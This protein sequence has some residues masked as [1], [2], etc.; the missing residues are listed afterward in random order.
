MSDVFLSLLQYQ[1]P[2]VL[3]NH[4]RYC[5]LQ[6]LQHVVV[7]LSAAPSGQ[8]RLI[9]QLEATLHH[10]LRL[11]AD[12]VLVCAGDQVCVYGQQHAVPS[13][14]AGHEQ[15]LS[16]MW[17]L[18]A[19]HGQSERVYDLQLWRHTPAVVQRLYDALAASK[20]ASPAPVAPGDLFGDGPW[21]APDEYVNGCL[22]ALECHQS[23]LVRWQDR[24]DVW[25]LVM[26]TR[27]G[28]WM[29]ASYRRVV[30]EAVNRM[31]AGGPRVFDVA[32][33]TVP[34]QESYTV[35]QPQGRVAL[36]MLYTPNIRFYGQFAECNV[37]RYCARH[38]YAFHVY[39][40]VPEGMP[41]GV[42]GNWLKPHLLQRHLPDHEWVVWVDADMMFL[43]QS[44]P[45]EPLLQGRDVLAAHDIGNWVLNS[46]L[47]GFRQ[48]PDNARVLAE[49]VNRSEQLSDRSSV[50][51]SDGDQRV[52][53]DVL[54]GQQDWKLA[55]G[56]DLLSI[57]T[58]WFYRQADSLCVHYYGMTPQ[59]R[60]LLMADDD[61]RVVQ[62]A[63]AAVQG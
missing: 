55:D 6:G 7:D 63:A 59:A 45:L 56:W 3:D 54:T 20:L 62:R 52:F 35:Q 33:Q 9:L 40:D 39:R 24:P 23:T 5:E 21:L 15:L 51:A 43:D 25:C 41:P 16:R 17:V 11:P 32:P 10:L 1:E 61:R 13:L 14:A 12:G 26:R 29:P 8:T 46:G 57:N 49:V 18:G 47:L 50:Y 34:P 48:T 4:A 37:A 38:G 36:V 28:E 19:P 31:Q 2:W 60:A 30:F 22:L 42:S 58:P 53:C 44:Q 27:P